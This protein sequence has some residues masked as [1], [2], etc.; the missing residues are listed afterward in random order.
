MPPIIMTVFEAAHAH[1]AAHEGGL[2]DHTADPGGI[3]NYGI[4]IKFLQG[5]A[6]TQDGR[7]TL[8]RIGVRLPVTRQTILEMTPERA[9]SLMRWQFWI[10]PKLDELPPLIAVVLYDLGVNAGM[11]RSALL[12]Q[13]AINTVA[14]RD[15]IDRPA[16][17]VGPKTRQYAQVMADAGKELQ[18]AL[19]AL[20]K[21][22]NWYR[23]LADIKP[24]S[25]VFLKGWLRR[26]ENC[27]A[28]VTKLHN[29]QEA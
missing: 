9:R 6:T 25:A 16:A 28:L 11:G 29:E 12:L 26:T 14:G 7:D 23:N 22:A 3:T 20:D 10:K 13:E 4:S 24:T 5:I 17:N 1:V 21:R 15:L 19:T 8:E 2:S 27:R 18:L